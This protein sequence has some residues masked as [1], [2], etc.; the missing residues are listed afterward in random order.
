MNNVVY[1]VLQVLFFHLEIVLEDV[2]LIKT[3]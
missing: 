3:T 1:S 2:D